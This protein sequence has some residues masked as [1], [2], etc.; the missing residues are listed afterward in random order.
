MPYRSAAASAKRKAPQDPK[1]NGGGGN[2]GAC[3]ESVGSP[4][5]GGRFRQRAARKLRRNRRVDAP[6]FRVCMS[7]TFQ[8]S[9]ESHS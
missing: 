4:G 5:D 6:S 7:S 8:S 9:S 3:E 1:T 2:V